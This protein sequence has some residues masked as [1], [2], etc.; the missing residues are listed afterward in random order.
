MRAARGVGNLDAAMPGLE[1]VTPLRNRERIP[2]SRS[3]RDTGL[4][5]ARTSPL[6]GASAP[7]GA[8]LLGQRLHACVARP[9]LRALLSL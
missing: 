4:Q 5:C 9:P 3:R 1:P 8:P 7:T 2:L 6:S